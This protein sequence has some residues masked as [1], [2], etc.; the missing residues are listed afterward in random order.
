M[1]RSLDTVQ[2]ES[3]AEVEEI[4]NAIAK[5]VE[6]NPKEKENKVLK[7]FYNYLDIMDMEW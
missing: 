5:Y 3:R 6:A 7:Q 2:F 1:Q 4:M